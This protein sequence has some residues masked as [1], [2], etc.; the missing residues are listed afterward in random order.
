M[1][2]AVTLVA[3]DRSSF[4]G[5]TKTCLQYFFRVSISLSLFRRKPWTKK[6]VSVHGLSSFE[7][8]I[9]K[10]SSST[11]ISLSSIRLRE[12]LTGQK[13]LRVG[14]GERGSKAGRQAL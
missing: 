7:T 3:S 6:G 9:P 1:S 12:C 10:V 14:G 5:S 4:S 13:N 8:Y 2:S 11:G